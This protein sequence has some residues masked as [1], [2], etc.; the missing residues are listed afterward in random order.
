MKM[1]NGVFTF[2]TLVGVGMFVVFQQSN[3]VQLATGSLNA[4]SAYVGGIAKIGM[5]TGGPGGTTGAAGG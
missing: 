3:V 1:I 5:V 2:A 4:I